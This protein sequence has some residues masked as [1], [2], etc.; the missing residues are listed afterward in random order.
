MNQQNKYFPDNN[1][2]DEC[3]ADII[4]EL[5]AYIFTNSIV[6]CWTLVAFFFYCCCLRSRIAG[7]PGLQAQ[8]FAVIGSI[9]M[10][11]ALAILLVFVPRCPDRCSSNMECQ[12]EAIFY[13]PPVIAC[14]VAICWLRIAY[15]RA[16]LSHQ[17]RRENE[18][19]GGGGDI[20]IFTKVPGTDAETEVELTE[21]SDG[22]EYY[23]DDDDDVENNKFEI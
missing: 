8:Y 21:H 17:L 14:L 13:I 2:D 5:K 6:L 12:E 22:I 18:G 10:A 15:N 4:S 3:K 11:V 9:Q 16:I 23:N 1:T 7:S 19:V 20:A